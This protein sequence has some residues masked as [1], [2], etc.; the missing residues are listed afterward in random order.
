[1]SEYVGKDLKRV[2]EQERRRDMS[3]RLEAERGQHK[4]FTPPDWP[5]PFIKEK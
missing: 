5:N 2:T 3:E 4:D 1:M